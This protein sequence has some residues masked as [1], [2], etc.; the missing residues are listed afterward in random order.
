M[1]SDSRLF[2]QDPEEYRKQVV[3][4]GTSLDVVNRAIQFGGTTLLQPVTPK[5]LRAAQRGQTGT[6]TSTDYTG[7]GNWRPT[8][9]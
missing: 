1:R 3:A 7:S 8:R 6:V 2:L 5:G 9:R 4:A